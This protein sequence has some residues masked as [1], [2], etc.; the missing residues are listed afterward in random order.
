MDLIAVSV[1]ESRKQR[2][3]ETR[4]KWAL[5]IIKNDNLHRCP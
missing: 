2:L 5:Q 1:E 3:V 4:A